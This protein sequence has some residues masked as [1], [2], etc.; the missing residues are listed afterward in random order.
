MSDII[1]NTTIGELW[2]DAA[3][4]YANKTFLVFE[5]VDGSK[6]SYSYGSFYAQICRSA[7]LF[8]SCGIRQGDMVLMQLCNSAEFLMVF[9]GL[10]LIGAVVVPLASKSS[11]HELQQALLVCKPKWA[12]VNAEHVQAYSE[13]AKAGEYL[14]GGVFTVNSK[15]KVSSIKQAN[16]L[17]FNAKLSG[18]SDSVPPTTVTDNMQL[19]E[20]LFTSGTT[21]APKAVMITHANLVFSGIY[22]NWQTSMRSDDRLLSTMP[23][24][25][26]NFQMAALMPVLVAG[27]TLILVERYSASRFCSQLRRHRA[28]ITQLISMMVRTL[29]LQPPKADD[30]Q[31]DLREALYFMPL[32]DV[33]KNAFEQRFNARLMNTYGSTETIGWAVTDSP[34]GKRC[35]P[36]V[37]KAGLGYEVGIFN[38]DGKEVQPGEV[39][40]F[41]VKGIAGRTLALGYYQ[42]P[43]LSAQIIDKN[44]WM[45]T[46]D[47][48][49]MNADG[50]F[51]FCDRQA[52][53]IKRAGE[54]VSATEVETVLCEHP[55]ISEAAVIGVHDELR[56]EAVKAFVLPVSGAFLDKEEIKQWCASKLASYKIPTEIEFVSEFPR[57]VS[58]KIEKRLL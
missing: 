47:K 5:A 42:Q 49:Y 24:C 18:A 14:C 15:G 29:L 31:N 25:H 1:G 46:G 54:N 33:E 35:W 4:T 39:G 2:Q 57:T 41:R 51:Y 52:N 37:G 50:W 11:Q 22:G 3:C 56:D 27:A 30:A 7:N 6:Q 19:A 28:T 13:I 32:S 55:D 12:V 17:D 21:A 44:G 23:A 34:F 36:S 43:E 45:R 16:I 48:G 20:L 38:G 9:F 26:S 8:Y 40:E 53:I 10:N 58:M